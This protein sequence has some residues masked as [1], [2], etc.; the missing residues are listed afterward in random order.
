MM[1][2]LMVAP[3]LLP[4]V[5]PRR[6]ERYHCDRVGVNGTWPWLVGLLRLLLDAKG[7]EGVNATWSWLVGLLLLPGAKGGLRWRHHFV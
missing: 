7:G 1:Q 4:P 5:L 2:P 3:P 6:R